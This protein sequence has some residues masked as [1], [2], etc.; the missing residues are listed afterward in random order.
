MSL[1]YYVIKID[2]FFSRKKRLELDALLTADVKDAKIH[3]AV[4]M[5]SLSCTFA[6]SEGICL[7][8]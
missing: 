5:V 1:Y 7:N 4:R 8:C 6:Y 3:T 2:N